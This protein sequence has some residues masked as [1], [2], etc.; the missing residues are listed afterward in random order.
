MT[1]SPPAPLRRGVIPPLVT[2]LR[3]RDQLDLPALERLTEHLVA[4]GARGLILLGSVGEP[5]GL[6]Y[7]LRRELVSRACRQVAGRL[8]VIV[9][10]TDTAVVEALE[11]ARFAAESGVASLLLA[12]PCHHA[13]N[14]TDVLAHVRHLSSE[15]PLPLLLDNTP[16]RP[17]PLFST[18]TVRRLMDLPGV[19]GL[20]DASGDMRAF[21]RLV[22]LLPHR[23][24]WT[25]LVG[26]DELF[27]ESVLLGGHGGGGPASCL[28]PSLHVAL[29]SAA[30]EHDTA[31]VAILHARI[32]RLANLLDQAGSHDLAKVRALKCALRLLG[33]CDD[34]MAEPSPRLSESE[35][36]L[37]QTRLDEIGLT[38]PASARRVVALA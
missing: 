18:D 36:R 30:L 28:H 34:L 27:A 3:G 11:F 24:E 14:Q 38:P 4:N 13:D 6:S 21:H 35:R 25:L 10:L 22:G 32:L 9:G 20:R 12:P 31:R 17:G 1:P 29:H 37:L 16:V 2:P 5:A 23:P 33:L 26:A 8:P 7:R 15:L 19:I